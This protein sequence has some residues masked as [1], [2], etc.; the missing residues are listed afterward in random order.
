MRWLSENRFRETVQKRQTKD[1]FC[2]NAI[3]KL[4]PERGLDFS[5]NI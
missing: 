1:R 3:I 4:L 2:R 5:R